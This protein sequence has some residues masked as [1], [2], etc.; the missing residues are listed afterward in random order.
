MGKQ[1]SIQEVEANLEGWDFLDK[2]PKEL[3]GFTLKKGSGITGQV[4][5]IASYVNEQ[6]HT[7]LQLTY[8]GET[9]DYVPVKN[10][11]LHNFRDIRYF[12]RNR[13]DFAKA[14]LATDEQGRTALEKL[15]AGM[16]RVAGAVYDFEYSNLGTDKWEYVKTL[17]EKIGNYELYITPDKPVEYI[18]GSLI[19]LD[20]TDFAKGNQLYF[21]YNSYRNEIYAGE[22]KNF[23]PQTTNLFTVPEENIH[24]ERL[25]RKGKKL[26]ND[27]L[28][29]PVEE[30]LPWLTEKMEQH[31]V[32]ELE[33][34]SK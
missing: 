11:G 25:N 4:L 19:F 1:L 22:K 3:Q 29:Y 12:F 2:L 10:I 23:K 24:G 27:M 31:L 28:V 33:Q 6:E 30:L 21:V 20:Y 16:K 5:E 9:Y 13:D 14:L 8:T 26:V 17:P 32:E 18:T 15:L 7:C 34:L